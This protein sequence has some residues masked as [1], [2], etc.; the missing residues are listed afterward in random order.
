MN[1]SNSQK[2]QSLIE[3]VFAIAIFTVGVITVGY[4]IITALTSLH[5]ATEATQARLLA[6]E[7]IEAVRAIREGGFDNILTGT[8]GLVLEQG[9]WTFASS[10]DT[11]GKFSRTITTEDIDINTKKVTSR[12]SWNMYGAH[13]KSISYTIRFTNWKQTG[14]EAGDLLVS[15]DLVTL[16]ASSTALIGLTIQNNSGRDITLTKMTL[17]WSTPALLEHIIIDG[18]DIFSAS[19]SAPVVSGTEIDIAD[20]SIGGSSGSHPFDTISFNASTEG[21]NFIILFTMQDGSVRSVYLT[22]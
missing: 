20:Y 11:Q 3:I 15:T 13:E 7:G 9:L 16:D 22:P 2:G 17:L 6:T 8:Y 12:V 14:G 21:S 10:S 4:L 18:F 5:S 1:T 19:T